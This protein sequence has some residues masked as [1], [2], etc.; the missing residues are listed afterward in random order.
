[1][2]SAFD[3]PVVHEHELSNC[4]RASLE[5]AYAPYSNFPVG[6]AVLDDLG[7]IFTGVNV[8]NASYGLTIC[9]ERVAIFSAIAHGARSIKAVAVA[10][11]NQPAVVP[12]G[13]CRQVIAEFCDPSVK[14]LSDAGNGTLVA[15]TVAELLPHAFTAED[16][17]PVH[18]TNRPKRASPIREARDTSVAR[19]A[20]FQKKR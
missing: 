12:C 9:A 3:V 19:A 8:E 11:K 5:H 6:A 1:M 4:A 13:A 17:A 16:L 20:A 18:V 7:R 15:W 14:I 10:A 2:K